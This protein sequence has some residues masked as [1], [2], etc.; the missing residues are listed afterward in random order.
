[1]FDV[2]DGREHSAIVEFAP[3]QKAPKNGGS[4]K[5]DAKMGSLESDR[6]YVKFMRALEN[7]EESEQTTGKAKTIEQYMD[8][9]EAKEREL[10]NNKSYTTP[11]L[12]FVREQRKEKR[13]K[14][15]LKREARK[16]RDEERKRAREE[17]RKARRAKEGDRGNE[18]GATPRGERGGKASGGGGRRSDRPDKPP[19]SS[20]I[21]GAGKRKSQKKNV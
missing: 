3:N 11:L 17:E 18:A 4:V 5:A 9:I 7:P 14:R 6:D 10:K 13:A 16:R 12:D 15:D 20:T 21:S 2:G 19:K 8:E 1:M